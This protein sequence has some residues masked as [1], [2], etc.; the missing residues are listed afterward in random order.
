M[1]PVTFLTPLR[2]NGSAPRSS[3][4]FTLIE[5]LVVIAIIAILAAILFPVFAQAREKVRQT[6]CLSNTKQMGTAF[7]MYSQDYDETLPIHLGDGSDYLNAGNATYFRVNW[8]YLI[9][10]YNKSKS[11]YVCPSA[12]E[13]APPGTFATNSYQGNG[14]V[15]SQSGTPLSAITNPSDI[16]VVSESN[17]IQNYLY[18]RPKQT[19]TNPPAFVSWHLVDCRKNYEPY[20]QTKVRTGCGE[21][22]NA[23]HMAGGNLIFTD[24][25]AKW[26][27]YSAIR[28]GDY[29]LLP[30]EPYAIQGQSDIEASGTAVNKSYTAAFTIN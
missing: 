23:V 3:N 10:P 18:N 14:V 2:K 27:K 12:Y 17:F 20:L 21:A 8:A 4:A 13:L 29:G 5:L 19:A 24:G 11:I 1:M 25:H 30:D 16:I 15:L 9:F 26:R 6:V 7:A 28:S 22:Y